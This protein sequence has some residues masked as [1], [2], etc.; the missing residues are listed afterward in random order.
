MYRILIVDDE[1]IERNGI[2]TLLKK[3]NYPLEI[4]EASDGEDALQL[5]QKYSIDILFTDIKMPFMDGLELT[6]SVLK[7]N[8]HILVAIFSGYGEFSYAQKAISMGVSHY[9]LKP[10]DIKEL[11]DI[12]NQ[13]LHTLNERKKEEKNR[14][15]LQTIYQTYMLHEKSNFI[16]A[17]INKKDI[18][19]LSHYIHEFNFNLEYWNRGI[20]PVNIYCNAADFTN[21]ISFE[22]ILH[23]IFTQRTD[24]TI[25]SNEQAFILIELKKEHI[26][27]DQLQKLKKLLEHQTGGLVCIAI[28][29]IIYHANE[30]KQAYRQTDELLDCRFFMNKSTIIHVSG[31]S[32]ISTDYTKCIRDLYNQ[33]IE[34]LSLKDYHGAQRTSDMLF[35]LLQ[36]SNVFSQIYIKYMQT[37]IIGIMFEQ[38]LLYSDLNYQE[39]LDKLFSAHSLKDL[40]KILDDIFTVI[41]QKNFLSDKDNV[42][43]KIIKYIGDNYDQD[44]SLESISREVHLAPGY[45]SHLFRQRT[46]QSF[47]QYLIAF[48]MN[49]AV[50]FLRETDL[51][52]N[53]IAIKTGYPNASYFIQTFKNMYGFTPTQFRERKLR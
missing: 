3:Y 20:Q 6:R 36:N 39:I 28:G 18:Q 1:E 45:I 25:I 9:I 52:V 35:S 7:N 42:I 21:L 37:K 22:K 44:L 27:P 5:I 8:P 12:M 19:H 29:K 13:I 11:K 47:M 31:S 53:Q 2:H 15:K 10:I 43:E 30:L 4:Y 17:L 24:Y 51:K 50:D 49:K 14:N 38:Y 23:H 26:I 34:L 41:K 16:H 46:G 32:I 33:T 40:K 48:R